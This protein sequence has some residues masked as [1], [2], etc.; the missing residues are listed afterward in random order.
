MNRPGRPFGVAIAIIAGAFLFSLLPLLQVGMALVVRQHFLNAASS[1]GV[2]GTFASGGEFL[3]SGSDSQIGLQ[4]V[5]A[6]IFLVIAVFTWRGRPAQMR[7]IYVG[8]VAA[9]TLIKLAT[10]LSLTA[11]QPALQDG[12]S[13]GDDL[14]RTLAW[15]QLVLEILVTLYVVWYMNRGPARAFFRGYYLPNPAGAAN[16]A[17]GR[18]AV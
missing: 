1:G 13:S 17:P 14:S 9:F 8:A 2:F 11:A 4:T 18:A 10:A 12:I 16:E 3:G 5:L 7:F 6:L 15:G